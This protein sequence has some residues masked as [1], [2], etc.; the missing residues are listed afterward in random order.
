MSITRGPVMLSDDS[1]FRFS[2]RGKR[3]VRRPTLGAANSDNSCF[4]ISSNSAF[5]GLRG[6]P[7]GRSLE[8]V[9]CKSLVRVWIKP[10]YWY[11][12]R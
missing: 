12:P 4:G 2:Q 11:L 9:M 5:D 8:V 1:T 7:S 10:D 6:A 3:L